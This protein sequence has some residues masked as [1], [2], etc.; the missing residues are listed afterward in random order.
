[1]AKIL[2]KNKNAICLYTVE[3]E[4][5]LK[6]IPGLA[7]I[8]PPPQD[9]RCDCCERHISEL[10][11][12]G[13]AGDPL[14]GDFNGALLVKVWRPGGPYDEEAERAFSEA[15]NYCQKEG[16]ADILDWMKKRHVRGQ[17]KQ[18]RE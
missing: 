4:K 7:N 1:M 6:P 16:I 10:K 18:Q 5:D 9:G 3:E 12:Y 11:Q 13:K 14:I 8:N 15:L 17:K 2:V